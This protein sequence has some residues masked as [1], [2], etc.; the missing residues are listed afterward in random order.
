MKYDKKILGKCVIKYNK[1]ALVLWVKKVQDGLN[2]T[3]YK[4]V[5]SKFSILF[6]IE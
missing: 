2:S 5:Q 4:I 6:I 1:D 3:A